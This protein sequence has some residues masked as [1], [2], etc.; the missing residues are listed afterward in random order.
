MNLLMGKNLRKQKKERNLKNKR[1]NKNLLAS[2]PK[3]QMSTKCRK[4][5]DKSAVLNKALPKMLLTGLKI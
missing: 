1:N 3:P 2:R 5:S 4:K